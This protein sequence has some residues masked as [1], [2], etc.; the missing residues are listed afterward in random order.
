MAALRARGGIQVVEAVRERQGREPGTGDM[1]LDLA[2]AP[3]DTIRRALRD[4]APDVIVN[5][6]GRTTG[7][8][9]ELLQANAVSVARLLEALEALEL[10]VRL[11]HVGSA[12]EYGPGPVGI[13]V[14]ESAATRPTGAYGIS[15]L[16]GTQIVALAFARGVATGVILRPFNVLGPGMPADTLPG[17]AIRSLQRA[18]ETQASFIDMGPLDAVRDFVDVRDTAVAVA[19]ASTAKTIDLPLINIGSGRG[20]TARELVEELARRIG[21]R[22]HVREA[23]QGSPRSGDVPWQ[24]ADISQAA[25]ALGWHPVHD[26]SDSCAALIGGATTSMAGGPSPSAAVG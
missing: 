13:P 20:H 21:F 5:C 11:I 23:L 4:A 18:R 22:G 17:A 14:T 10:H 1:V 9:V 16:A 26:L 19:A 3:L 25:R 6:S 2:T 8:A 24:V 15:K 12:A 7:T